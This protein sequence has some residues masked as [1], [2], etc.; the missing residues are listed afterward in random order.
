[1]QH[2]VNSLFMRLRA[3]REGR[4]SMKEQRMKNITP[5]AENRGKISKMCW[6]VR[7][8]EVSKKSLV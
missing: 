4:Q 5:L 3:A 2:V 1:M 8:V 7:G 6:F